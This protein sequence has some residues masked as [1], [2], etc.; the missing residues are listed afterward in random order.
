MFET[1]L[2]L[3]RLSWL[4]WCFF[5]AHREAHKHSASSHICHWCCTVLSLI[6]ISQPKLGGKGVSAPDP[7]AVPVSIQ[8]SPWCVF[9]YQNLEGSE[10]VPLMLYQYQ[11]S[12]L[13]DPHFPTKT[14]RE[15]ILCPWCCTSISTVLSLIHI[16]QLKLGGKRSCV[17]D[18]VPVSVQS[19]PWS[20]FPNQ[21]LE[22]RE[23]LLGWE[24][25]D[26]DHCLSHLKGSHNLSS[27]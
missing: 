25:C 24:H 2:F 4:L 26:C 6:H 16:S 8:S 19:S 3:L 23:P 11:Y 21:N 1:F 20:L 18:A 17:L 14:W 13:L 12:P 15:A 7:D 27:G 22:G 10:P 9:S 5:L